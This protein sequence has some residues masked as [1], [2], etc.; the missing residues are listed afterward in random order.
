[1]FDIFCWNSPI[2]SPCFCSLLCNLLAHPS[3]RGI[4][5]ATGKLG[6]DFRFNVTELLFLTLLL[7]VVVTVVH[8]NPE[9]LPPVADWL[10][11]SVLP[12]PTGNVHM[13]HTSADYDERIAPRLNVWLQETTGGGEESQ[14]A[15]NDGLL[16]AVMC[17]AG[18]TDFSRNKQSDTT[19][20]RRPDM[21]I[22]C[23]GVPIVMVEE[24]EESNIAGA[25][26]DL[27]N[28]FV[29]IP[30]LRRL[31]FFIGFAFCFTHVRIVQFERSLPARV[32]F[33]GPC[34]TIA[35][36]YDVLKP[37]VNVARVLKY[38]VDS[39]L[40][41]PAGLKMGAWHP[42]QCGKSIR[43]SATGVEV[44]C[45]DART[46]KLLKALYL[47]C[48][49]VPYLEHATDSTA[50][51]R[52]I[53]LAPLGLSVEPST[54]RELGRAISCV[55]TAVFGMHK[56]GY[57]HTDIRWSNVVLLDNDDWLVIDCY[58]ACLISDSSMLRER[59]VARG[60][61]G[62]E[63]RVSDDIAQISRLLVGKH[64]MIPGLADVIN[65]KDVKLQAILAKCS[66][67]L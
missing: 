47:A 49:N 40:V 46:F 29:W 60:V 4:S 7:H 14:I 16:K 66:A 24:K 1:L 11:T 41:Y 39:D 6:N 59:A 52:R 45:P 63:W 50:K 37:A 44:Q 27:I 38:F 34:A 54:A 62:R 8:F 30:H 12:L 25:V 55:A 48:R 58:D 18:L 42:R 21:T 32:I 15:R 9:F 31:P 56:V 20:F 53:T 67:V 19:L 3:P 43:L 10:N 22:M 33:S 57:V 61:T 28:K 26:S 51:T 17:I 65:K 23:N 13:T 36:R 35:D 64:D 2:I 5:A